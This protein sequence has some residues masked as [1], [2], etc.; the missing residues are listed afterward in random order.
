MNLG[1]EFHSYATKH[2]GVKDHELNTHFGFDIEASMTPYILE[3]RK[4]RVTQM[5]IFSRLMRDR[6]IWL[7]GP[8][9]D[10]MSTIAQAQLMFLDD[11]DNKDITLHIDSPGGSVKSGLSIVDVMEYIKS[12]VATVNTGMCASMGSVLLGAGAKGK[13]SSLRFSQ[14]MCHQVSYGAGGNVQDVRITVKE[15]EKA[16]YILSKMLANYSGKSFEEYMETVTRDKW[17][18]STEA[19][20]FGLIDEVIGS[21]TQSLDELLE[22]FEDYYGKLTK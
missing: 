12:D 19:K 1:K 16:N 4:M 7:A 14:V 3:E 9:N 13:R 15:A 8:V 11:V 22:G 2:L 5:D 18:T 20:E 21:K 17:Y 6:I 10:R